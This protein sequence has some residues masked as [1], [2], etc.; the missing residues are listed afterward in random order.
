MHYSIF[1]GC[2]RSDIE[3]PQLRAAAQKDADWVFSR[4]VTRPGPTTVDVIGE[5]VVDAGVHVRASRISD[6]FRLEYDDSDVYDI[7]EHG[8]RITWYPLTDARLEPSRM[9]VMGRVL[10]VALHASGMLTLTGSAVEIEESGI[11]LLAPKSQGKSTLALALTM[12]GARL[13]TDDTVPL[14]TGIPTR[15]VPGVQAVRVSGDTVARMRP[16]RSVFREMEDGFLGLDEEKLATRRTPL[17]AVYILQQVEQLDSGA[18]VQR[19]RLSD[20]EAVMVVLRHTKAGA[21]LGGYEAAL[22]FDNV[23]SLA[24]SVPIYHLTI[25]RGL[26]RLDEVVAQML[27]WH[28]DRP[29]LDATSDE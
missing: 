18:A 28:R 20:V 9:D 10:A 14:E 6:G 13:L 21:L 23:I 16:D 25:V 22:V 15:I 7:T 5:A 26:E 12:G 27:E 19:V 3:F 11:A 4:V 1:G 2:L 8:S 29:S 17:G 24:Q